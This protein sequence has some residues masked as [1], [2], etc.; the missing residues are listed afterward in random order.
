MKRAL[1]TV[2][3]ITC[4]VAL[5]AQSV[6]N[7]IV[8]GPIPVTVAA[9]DASHDYPFFATNV[10]LA[11]RGYVEQEFFFEGTAN[12]YNI[13]PAVSKL[14]TAVIT[15]SGYPYR[16]RMIIRRPFS[17]EEF[18]GTV[19]MEWQNNAAG[20]DLD[21]LWADSHEHFMRRGYAWIGVSVQS[22]GVMGATFGLRAWSPTRY[23]T[24]N[25]ANDG[26]SWD[27]FSQAAQAVRNPVG[28]D[29][30][31]GLPVQRI[32]AAGLSMGANRVLAYHN[33]IHPLTEIFD[34]YL[35]VNLGALVRTDLDVKV[36][37][38][39]AETDVAGNANAKSQA[40]MRQPNSDHFRRWEVAG[41][42][43][44]DFHLAQEFAP[45]QARDGLPVISAAGCEQ[46]AFSRI[47][48]YFV[49]NAAYDQ[50]VNWVKH[51]V[52]P[53]IAPDIQ[54]QTLGEQVSVL[55]RDTFGNALGGIRLPQHAVPSATNTGLNFPDTPPTN[56]CRTFGS[57]VP[58]DATTLDS[59]YP[60]HQSY[61]ALV[62]TATHQGQQGG[63]IVGA[64]AAATIRE[65]AQS[66]VGRGQ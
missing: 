54:V 65:A 60:D 13:N 14:E 44:L 5:S 49:I 47:P 25:V 50:M 10:D 66:D 9:G 53:P 21:A 31:G 38:L 41:A 7:P 42:A 58:F 29:P 26:L 45:L 30:M 8:T 4:A 39:L 32:F 2:V 55:A 20:Y 62:I 22:V 1:L 24:L 19:I 63:F 56:F 16:T 43:H 64:D 34:G 23:A 6:P 27:I 28:L 18:N 3:V 37:K 35:L 59:F 40:W 11:G 12:T 17:A 61:L 48:F 36:F 33:S 52:Q 57:Y 15:G 51:D 46:P